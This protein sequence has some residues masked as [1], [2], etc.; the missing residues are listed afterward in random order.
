MSMDM[1]VQ[2]LSLVRKPLII[3]AP[4]RLISLAP[5]AVAV[6]RGGGIGFLGAGTDVGDL[7]E[8]LQ[9]ASQLIKQAL[10]PGVPP[11]VLLI[12][13]GFINW[14]A[15][16]EAAVRAMGKFKPTAVLFFA[17]YRNEDLV[18]W[19]EAMREATE[20]ITKIWIQVGSV[21]DALEVVE[22]CSPD[23]I[24]VQGSDAG[25]HGLERSA[26]IVNLFPRSSGR[27]A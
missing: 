17:P 26:G 7:E 5:L 9:E 23:V 27:A 16:L 3:S 2:G 4:M 1:Y 6:S 21:R 24:V 22:L 12:G 13:V 11:C 25:G 18:Q 19:I 20:D 10:I 14:G 15:N 8:R